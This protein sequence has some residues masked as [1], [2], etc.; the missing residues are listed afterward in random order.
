MVFITEAIKGC[1]EKS[2][3]SDFK[4]FLKI[5]DRSASWIFLSDFCFDDDHK[6]SNSMTFSVLLVHDKFENIKECIKKYQPKDIKKSSEASDGFLNYLNSPVIF[7]FSFIIR[8]NDNYFSKS[9]SNNNILIYMNEMQSAIKVFERDNPSTGDYFREVN[10]RISNFQESTK[11]KTFNWKLMRK[12]MITSCI[13]SIIFY[14]LTLT[15]K[16]LSIKWLSDRDGI[17]EKFDSISLDIAFL[18]YIMLLTE[19]HKGKDYLDLSFIP[20]IGFLTSKANT[21]DDYE[22][23]VRIP[24][25]IA[26]TI[27]ELDGTS[28][29]FK[30]NKYGDVFYNSIVNSRNH[31]IIAI[32][33]I[34][35]DFYIRRIKYV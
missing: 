7:H 5:V 4:E 10:K 13:V 18:N 33:D 1:I 20:Q 12:I 27:A 19:D 25:F 26:G 23:L 32:D 24:D 31:S 9:L 11:A 22:E 21:I 8:K 15:N 16:P 29:S 30:H 34:I 2:T 35:N 6:K 17:V 3:L 14:E 28:Y